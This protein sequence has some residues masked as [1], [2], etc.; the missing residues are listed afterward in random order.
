MLR[1][2]GKTFREALGGASMDF[3][4]EGQNSLAGRRGRRGSWQLPLQR[5]ALFSLVPQ[6]DCGTDLRAK[7]G[8]AAVGIPKWNFGTRLHELR[9]GRSVL[10]MR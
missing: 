4:A 6:L 1:V 3:F 8:F 10:P 7:L 5:S 9:Y 2:T